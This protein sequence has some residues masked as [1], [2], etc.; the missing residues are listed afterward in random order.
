MEFYIERRIVKRG[1]QKIKL[2]DKEI[3][4]AGYVYLDNQKKEEFKEHKKNFI[5]F[6]K[7]QYSS[8]FPKF[9]LK[10]HRNYFN[11]LLYES[12]NCKDYVEEIGFIAIY[13]ITSDS[14]KKL[15]ELYSQM[16]EKLSL[17][18]FIEDL[19]LNYE[20]L[21]YSDLQGVVQARCMITKEDE[22]S[23]LNEINSKVNKKI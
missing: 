10:E 16:L 1:K 22:N 6:L 23:I 13:Q 18:E 19:V 8:K 12:F 5:K 7:E 15:K 2:T 9:L 14:R 11:I 21:S 3:E 17:E 4:L 20:T